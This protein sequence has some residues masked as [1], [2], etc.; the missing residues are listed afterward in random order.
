ME[1]VYTYMCH[2][3]NHCNQP[4]DNGCCAHIWHISLN[5]YGCHSAHIC[6]GSLLQWCAYRLHISTHTTETFNVWYSY[7]VMDIKDQ[8]MDINMATKC[9]LTIAMTD[10]YTCTLILYACTCAKFELGITNIV[11]CSTVCKT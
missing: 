4:C 3:W 11:T 9:K 10:K 6:S 2:I 5:K 8:V 1:D 7:K